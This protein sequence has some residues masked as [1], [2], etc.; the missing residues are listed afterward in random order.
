MVISLK[1]DL[2]IINLDDRGLT[3]NN[4]NK[5]IRQVDGCASE[6][7]ASRCRSDAQSPYQRLII[8]DT[9]GE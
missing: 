1:C 9:K 4:S 2:F 3:A 8:K 6:I 5:V 7:L